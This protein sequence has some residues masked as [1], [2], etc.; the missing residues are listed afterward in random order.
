MESVCIKSKRPL[1]RYHGGKW[2]L[3]PWIISHFPEHRIYVE[4]FGGA[5]SVLLRKRR[6]YAEVYNDLDE[7]IVNLFRVVRDNGEELRRCL[8]LTPFARIEFLQ[9]Y[10]PAEDPVEQARRTV[11]RS[12]MGYGTP[13]ASGHKTGF[14]SNSNRSGTTPAHDWKNYS[15]AVAA[16][17]DRLSGVVI[18]SRDF[19]E[20]METHDSPQALHY[21]DPP[22]V[23]DTRNRGNPYCRKG[24][25]RHEM[26]NDDHRRFAE[27]ARSMQG[28]VIVSGYD[29][30]LYDELFS[31]WRRIDYT[32]HA[33]GARDRIELLWISPNTPQKQTE[34]FDS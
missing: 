12:F 10:E 18:E 23:P 27:V 24:E 14:R 28:Y 22:Y 25:Y 26:T 15:D 8:K 32:T 19:A 5:A 1:L 31:D 33:D 21:C 3:A 20:I 34:L 6:S 17:I 2:L 11:V 4:P 16:T 9:S 29:S 13:S 30:E 7:E